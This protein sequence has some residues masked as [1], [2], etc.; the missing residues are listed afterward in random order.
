MHLAVYLLLTAIV[1]VNAR[2]RDIDEEAYETEKL[3]YCPKRER[4]HKCGNACE[5]SCTHP[6]QPSKRDCDRPCIP[7]V[8]LCVDGYYR[9]NQG[10]GGC[11]RRRDCQT[12]DLPQVASK[13]KTTKEP[14]KAP[15][16]KKI[17]K[18]SKDSFAYDD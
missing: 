2:D 17:K 6:K 1:A 7:H 11:V 8:C 5:K 10:T 14:K 9:D 15:R 16:K 13:K 12:W 3:T 4:W 18:P